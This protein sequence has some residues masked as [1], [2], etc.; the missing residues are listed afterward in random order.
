MEN[1]KGIHLTLFVSKKQSLFI[2]I[3][4]NTYEILTML[5]F[6]VQMEERHV[7]QSL[8]SFVGS[9]SSVCRPLSDVCI[10]WSNE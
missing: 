1:I 5:C 9:G 2:K 6:I 8:L 7:K 3:N 4:I 10:L